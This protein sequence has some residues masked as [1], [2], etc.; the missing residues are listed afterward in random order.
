M[1]HG[2]NMINIHKIIF[3]ILLLFGLTAYSADNSAQLSDLDTLDG[4]LQYAALH[5]PSLESSFQQ[6]KAALEQVPQSQALS[7]P[8]FTFGYFI[9][10]VE[11]RVGPQ[12]T[13]L[14]ITQAFP[15]FGKLTAKSDI[16]S[17]RA[18]A[19][20]FKYEAEKLKLYNA[21]KKNWYELAYLGQALKLAK[22]NLELMD[23][24]QKIATSKYR[25]SL[26]THPDVVRAQ[27]ELASLTEVV[28]SLESLK[29]P[30]S[31][32]LSAALNLPTDY[33][34]QWP[35]FEQVPDYQIDKNTIYDAVISS[36]P[37]LK[38]MSSLI[39][40]DRAQLRLARAVSSPDFAIGVDWIQTG[41]SEMDVADSGKD[42]VVLMFSMNLP[43]WQ[44]KNNAV[45]RQASAA[46]R[47]TELKNQQLKND[48]LAQAAQLIF[49]IE[50]A[51]RK[52]L[53]NKDT[54]GEKASELVKVSEAAY[55]N[56]TL[57]FL[58]LIDAQRRQ[59]KYMLDYYRSKTDYLKYIADLELLLGGELH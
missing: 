23:Y 35:E 26:A 30:Q 19:A 27:I 9:Q 25:S 49:Q 24:Y 52:M 31:A 10:N 39:E 48:K 6:W 55:Q 12:Q 1:L 32:K 37:E 11:T 3:I 54:L 43:I 13:R 14:G 22:D 28:Q 51:R 56:G 21:V 58:S 15:W 45:K 57:D 44:N 50:D 8:K 46:L 41:R 2:D 38:G 7:D 42:P 47:A 5:S 20:Q 33:Q 4:C 53:L 59:L 18:Q 29:Q 34:F 17:A 40:A 36:D 16:A